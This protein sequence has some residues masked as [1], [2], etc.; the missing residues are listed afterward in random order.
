MRNGGSRLTLSSL[1]EGTAAREKRVHH[2]DGRWQTLRSIGIS[3]DRRPRDEGSSTLDF[4]IKDLDRVSRAFVPQSFLNQ[5]FQINNLPI[6]SITDF[7][8]PYLY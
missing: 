4:A 8:L 3:D 6:L 5:I 1:V 2:D 7:L